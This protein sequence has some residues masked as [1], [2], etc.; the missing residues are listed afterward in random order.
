MVSVI[1]GFHC[2]L[3]PRPQPAFRCL[4]QGKVWRAWHLFSCEHDI[5]GKWRKFSEQTGSILCIVQL[6]TCSTLVCD[7]CPLLVIRAGSYLLGWLF[8]LFWALCIHVQL[9][10]F[11]HPFYPDVTHMRKDTRPSPAFLYC[12]RRKAGW[13]LGTRL[14]T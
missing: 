3:V 7:N 8:L 12:K 10:A 4:Q 14:L 11:Y 1:E 5:I 9:S 2:S 6:T 13:G